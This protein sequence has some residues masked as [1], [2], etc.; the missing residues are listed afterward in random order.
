MDA[1]GK[2]TLET[3]EQIG[4]EFELAGVGSRLLAALL[5][6]LYM[7]V[8]LIAAVVAV[9]ASMSR[10]ERVTERLTENL[11]R[12][13]APT[14]GMSATAAILLLL[15]V[16]VV[17]WGYYII[18]E[19]VTK[20]S[21]PG[22][23]TLGLRVIRDNGLPIGFAQ[24]LLRNLVRLV[25]FLPWGYGVG[26]I[27][28]FVTSRSQRLGDLVAGTLVVRVEKPARAAAYAAASAG[29]RLLSADER[30][31]VQR[32]VDR[33]TTLLPAARAQLSMVIATPLRNRL[34]ARM[35]LPPALLNA[36]DDD[37]WLERALAL[38]SSPP[39]EPGA[40]S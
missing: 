15:S 22:K 19:M 27:S 5:D 29:G 20:G 18:S 25:D 12:S 4:I 34:V 39:S 30:Q 33:R 3:P 36:P 28:V 2:L 32:Y 23:R 21:S 6:L 14:T 10:E 35:T 1:S 24:S 37:V 38:D 9:I 17:Q 40:A 11:A 13:E 26:L 7:L 16:F 8:F 31:L